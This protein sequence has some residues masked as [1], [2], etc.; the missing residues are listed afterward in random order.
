MIP[1]LIAFGRPIALG[2]SFLGRLLWFSWSL[3]TLKVL[4]SP[5]QIFCRMPHYWK[6]SDVYSWCNRDSYEEDHPDL[7]P[8]S[9]Y[10]IKIGTMK[11]NVAAGVRSGTWLRSCS[12]DFSMVT[13]RVPGP[14][15]PHGKKSLYAALA[16]KVGNYAPTARVQ[17][18][19][20]SSVFRVA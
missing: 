10:H 20:A 4:R 18:A 7:V 17:S 5:T 6:W 8:F 14:S 13:L 11:M 12:S 2:S 9:L 1:S 19:N 15:F 16:Y 3:T